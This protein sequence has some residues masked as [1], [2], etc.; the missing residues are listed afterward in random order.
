M[1]YVK[2]TKNRLES[3]DSILINFEYEDSSEIHILP[4]FLFNFVEIRQ[5]FK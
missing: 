2:I 1:Y 4:L 5:C 3:V